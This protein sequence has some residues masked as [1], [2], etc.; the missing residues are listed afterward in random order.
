MKDKVTLTTWRKHL[1]AWIKEEVHIWC[2]HQAN[3]HHQTRDR[4]TRN[5]PGKSNPNFHTARSG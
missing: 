5:A 4:E 2:K 3:L 1:F